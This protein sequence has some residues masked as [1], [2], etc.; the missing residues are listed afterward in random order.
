MAIL[1]TCPYCGTQTDVYEEFAGRSGPCAICGKTITVP[2]PSTAGSDLPSSTLSRRNRAFWRAS[3]A[4][5]ALRV[6]LIVLAGIV[7]ATVLIGNKPAARMGDS[8]SHG[9]VIVAG[10]PTVLIGG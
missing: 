8:T 10:Y 3:N 1:F 2:Y 4:R 7:A 9:G 5:S 6:V